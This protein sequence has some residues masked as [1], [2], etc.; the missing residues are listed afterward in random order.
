MTNSALSLGA[1]NTVMAAN[2]ARIANAE[3]AVPGMQ[4]G[5]LF[6]YDINTL[7][8]RQAKINNVLSRLNN[9]SRDP[10]NLGFVLTTGA[11]V[12][13]AAGGAALLSALGGW[14]Y[15]QRTDTKR[16]EARIS[17]YEQM[18]A[19]GID[20]DEA[21][22]KVYGSDGSGISDIMSKAVII[23]V[24]FGGVYLVSKFK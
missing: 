5:I 8:A 12:G 18:V 22:K 24:I 15:K 19:D 4:R 10:G 2:E 17:I 7:R 20:P 16:L 21:A 9:Q 3:A 6:R 14:I 23:A 13:I 1:L 11:I